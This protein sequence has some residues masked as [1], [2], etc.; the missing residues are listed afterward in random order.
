MLVLIPE[1]KLKWP[2]SVCDLDVDRAED[3]SQPRDLIEDDTSVTRSLEV[4]T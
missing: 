1:M 4:G 3:A 2:L